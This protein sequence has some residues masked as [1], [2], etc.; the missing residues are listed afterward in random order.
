MMG[1][2]RKSMIMSPEQ[3]KSTAWHEA[4]HALVALLLPNSDP[5]HKVSIIPRGWALGLTQYLPT[6]DKYTYSRDYFNTRLAVMMGGRVAEELALNEL[7][8]GAGS[9]IEQASKLARSMV[10]RYGMSEALGPI[11]FD[12]KDDKI[13]LGREL[14]RPRDYSEETAKLI[15]SEVNRLVMDGYSKAK[16][17]LSRHMDVLKALTDLLLVKE[18][19]DAE[20]T[21]EVCREAIVSEGLTP[22]QPNPEASFAKKAPPL[23]T[24]EEEEDEG[25]DSV[26]DENGN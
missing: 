25:E 16:E 7:T 24:E 21:V 9:D 15:D 6:E 5:L 1:V 12:K 13:F 10:C 3:K 17:L 8:T 19:I 20:E 14:A 11:S 2:E 22:P 18:T 4:G 23:E 26:D